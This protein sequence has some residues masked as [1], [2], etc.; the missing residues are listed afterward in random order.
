MAQDW[1]RLGMPAHS[2]QDLAVTPACGLAGLSLE[3]ATERQRL[4]VEVARHLRDRADG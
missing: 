4:A 2:L 3:E 1:Q